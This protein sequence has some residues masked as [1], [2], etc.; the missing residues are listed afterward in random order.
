[1]GTNLERVSSYAG[2]EGHIGGEDDDSR[3]RVKTGAGRAAR[4]LRQAELYSFRGAG[5]AGLLV[6]DQARS[7][8]VHCV[9]VFVFVRRSLTGLWARG[10]GSL[11]IDLNLAHGARNAMHGIPIEV[12]AV[13]AVGGLA[14]RTIERDAHVVQLCVTVTLE[15]HGL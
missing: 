4:R 12:A 3:L 1:M 9:L 7:L 5:Q 6:E 2:I 8:Y 10:R 11:K 14:F 15:L 13:D